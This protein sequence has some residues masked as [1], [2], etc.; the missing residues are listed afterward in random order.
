MASPHVAGLAALLFNKFPTLTA[1]EAREII[2][3]TSYDPNIKIPAILDRINAI[4]NGIINIYNAINLLSIDSLTIKENDILKKL[5][6]DSNIEK[7]DLNFDAETKEI[8]INCS[9]LLNSQSTKIIYELNDNTYSNNNILTEETI[10]PLPS[11]SKS[12]LY[13]KIENKNGKSREYQI[14]INKEFK[15]KISLISLKHNNIEL[16]KFNK[17]TYEYSIVIPSGSDPVEFEFNSTM[18]E[19]SNGSMDISY[20]NIKNEEYKNN[21]SKRISIVNG[22]NIIRLK[23]NYKNSS[24][25]PLIYTIN[26]YR[27]YDSNTDLS[28]L[29]VADNK[30]NEDFNKSVSN[31]TLNVLY[32]TK[33][34][35]INPTL[36]NSKGSYKIEK[37]SVELL[38]NVGL[39]EIGDNKFII[40]VTSENNLETK[41]YEIII[42]R[43]PATNILSKLIINGYNLNPIFKGTTNDY[44]LTVANSR[45]TISYSILTVENDA[46]VKVNN[47]VYTGENNF[48]LNVGSN[49]LNIVVTGVNGSDNIYTVTIN[50][51]IK[52][53]S[54]PS[55]GGTSGG[56][57]SGGSSSGSST[58]KPLPPIIKKD[59]KEIIKNKDASKKE[60][61]TVSKKRIEDELKDDSKE[62]LVIAASQ[63]KEKNIEVSISSEILE[64][65]KKTDKNIEIQFKNVT[66][67]FDKDIIKALK[68]KKEFRILYSAVSDFKDKESDK[69][70]IVSNIVELDIFDGDIKIKNFKNF[71]NSIPIIFD[72]D[73]KNINNKKNIAIYYLDEKNNKWIYAG[74]KSII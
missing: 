19:P 36:L 34:I 52:S 22:D 18:Y 40:T 11:R 21:I 67:L 2:R 45:S 31:Y 73:I 41:K 55:T 72:Y 15:N 33:K 6:F 74:G 29:L 43:K 62:K 23:S 60:V 58:A 56:G 48:N 4:G 50:R 27:N 68:I 16:L 39:L 20:L 42:T 25:S 7:Y 32:N 28:D 65:L 10:I 53:T 63:S 69:K 1:S 13:I 46:S 3:N 12:I 64:I 54:S 61:I 51:E 30:L 71:K 35:T 44:S 37:N 70:N 57:T 5:N 9:R 14:S 47:Q 17:D 24:V 26:V 38:N 8:K 49:I 59:K 66:F